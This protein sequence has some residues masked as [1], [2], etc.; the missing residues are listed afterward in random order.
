MLNGCEAMRR[1]ADQKALTER[2]KSMSDSE[3]ISWR[4]RLVEEEQ[5]E[6]AAKRLAEMKEDVARKRR[7]ELQKWLDGD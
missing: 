5:R 1:A 4:N 7:A 2:L 3:L 6:E